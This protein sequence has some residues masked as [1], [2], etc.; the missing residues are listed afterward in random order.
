M[1]GRFFLTANVLHVTLG[2]TL[3]LVSMHSAAASKW[4]LT[5]VSYSSFGVRVSV[6]FRGALNLF[7]SVNAY[8]SLISMLLTR[9]Q[10]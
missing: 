5:K 8:L 1:F 3:F 9:D 10:S 7:L 4:T 6:F 2:L